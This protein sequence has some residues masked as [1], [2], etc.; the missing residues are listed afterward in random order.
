MKKKIESLDISLKVCQMCEILKAN[1]D[2]LTKS[3]EKFTNRK[4]NLDTFLGN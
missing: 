4:N 2:D 1:V 3:Q